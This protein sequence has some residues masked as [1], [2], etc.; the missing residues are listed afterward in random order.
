MSSA[1]VSIETDGAVRAL[2]GGLDAVSRDAALIYTAIPVSVS[3]FILARQMGG[4][5]IYRHDG[6]QAHFEL[7]LRR[8]R[9]RGHLVP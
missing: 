3:A 7:R 1:L 8:V 9:V 6:R 4:D 2:V 5:L